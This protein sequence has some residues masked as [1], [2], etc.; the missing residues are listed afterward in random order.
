MRGYSEATLSLAVCKRVRPA[1]FAIDQAKYMMY[2]GEEVCPKILAIDSDCYC[3]EYLYPAELSRD[4]LV[5]QER[6]LDQYVW[7]R[8]YDWNNGVDSSWREAIKTKINV[9]VP[10]WALDVPEVIHGDPTLD[11]VLMTEQ[12]FLR[13]TD[14][15]PPRWLNK[16]SIRAVDH[17]K[18]MQSFLGWETVLRGATHIEYD[19]PQF[20]LCEEARSA[21]FWAMI[22]LKRIA[23][24]D[25]TDSATQWSTMVA[26]ELEQCLR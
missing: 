7:W 14:P 5:V 8:K 21:V 3:M 12:G 25:I 20:M 22:A 17:G 23:F 1:E 4:S 18:I 24:R 13:I 15:I 10:D 11:N 19:W 26:K 16:P 6:I 2:L 9:E